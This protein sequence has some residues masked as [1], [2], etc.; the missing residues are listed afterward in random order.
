MDRNTPSIRGVVFP[1]YLFPSP[2]FF[3][4]GPVT[5]YVLRFDAAKD[6]TMAKLLKENNVVWTETENRDP[7][8]FLP[9]WLHAR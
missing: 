3:N 1:F 6:G 2:P 7:Y 8:T 4:F 5:E 9:G